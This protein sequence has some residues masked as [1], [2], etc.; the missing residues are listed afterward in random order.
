MTG[1]ADE[2]IRII[3]YDAQWPVRF[4]QER[5]L[6]QRAIGSWVVG[7]IH[8]VGSTAVPGLDAKPIIDILV[9]VA[10]LATSRACFE[11]LVE[12]SYLHAPYRPEEMHWFCKPDPSCRTHHLH[13]TPIGSPRYRSE[14]AFRDHLRSNPA[15][16][17]AY[18]EL[19][20]WLAAKFEHDREGY[21]EAKADF[22]GRV[23]REM[24]P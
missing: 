8:H 13:L 9:G 19:K 17:Q 5:S 14:I 10:D 21:T 18:A 7:D 23:L 24:R 20:R 1:A 11:P 3:A 22:I 12:L 6:L 4:E 15:E 16:A 2:P